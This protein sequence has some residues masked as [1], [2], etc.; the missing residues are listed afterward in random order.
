MKPRTRRI[1]ET[2]VLAATSLTLLGHGGDIPTCF[3]HAT[4]SRSYNVVGTCGAPGIVTVSTDPC[5][6]TVTGDDVGLPT[7]GNLGSTLDS[8]FDLYGSVNADW[9]LMCTAF[10]P[11]GADA[12]ALKPGEMAL[13]CR[14]SPSVINPNPN[15]D[16]VNWCTAELVPVTPTCDVHACAPVTCASTEHTAFAATGCCPTCVANGPMD[17]IP[18]PPPP[19]CHR[20]M[21]PSCPAGQEPSF[22]DGTCCGTCQTPPQSCLDG[23]TQWL[24]E[25]NAR[26]SSARACT[27]DADCDITAAA[28]RCEITCSD[29]IADAQ[30][31]AFT[32]WAAGRADELCATCTTEPPEC[33][34]GGAPMRAVCNGGSC[35]LAPL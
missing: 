31:A 29:A 32:T 19:A 34:A 17:I 30:I 24:A 15:A 8:G 25:V 22:D 9:D 27:T 3:G 23:R 4:A 7:S 28:T 1:V 6:I 33:A 10:R 14:R 12:G 13:G 35:A 11:S 21:C 16:A 5:S 2:L 20:N 18:V 26:W